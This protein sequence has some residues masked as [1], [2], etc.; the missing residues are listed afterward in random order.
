MGSVNA[1]T[2][3]DQRKPFFHND[4]VEFVFSIP[5]EYKL[6]NRLYSVMLHKFFPKF[7]KDIPWQQTGNPAGV[8]K[9]NPLPYRIA[10]K[11][12]WVFC[13]MGL[14]SSPQLFT[15]YPEW[16]RDKATKSK[17]E[18]LLLPGDSFVNKSFQDN[19]E[20]NCSALMHLGCLTTAMKY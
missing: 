12:R 13:K 9:P 17:I 15:N 5:D 19:R 8:I 1:W 18:D 16:I 6:D 10:N 2:H 4:L 14:L 7:Y 3:V 20:K 11:V